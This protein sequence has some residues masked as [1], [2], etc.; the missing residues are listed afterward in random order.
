MV[1][2]NCLF[3]ESGFLAAANGCHS[4]RT[5]NGSPVPGSR[6]HFTALPG[7][8]HLSRVRDE[9]RQVIGVARA[10]EFP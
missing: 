5:G 3:P 6:K 2:L 1:S 9:E 4:V 10:L 8:Q 7:I